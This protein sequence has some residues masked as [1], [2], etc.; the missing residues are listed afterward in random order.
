[1]HL[2]D[3]AVDRVCHITF[4]CPPG[5]TFRL[6]EFVLVLDN[7]TFDAFALT[8]DADTTM[9]MHFIAGLIESAVQRNGTARDVITLVYNFEWKY[10]FNFR[11][12]LR[13]LFVPQGDGE[14]EVGDGDDDDG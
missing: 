2:S 5:Y 14:E 1:M 7:G 4:I 13:A 6:I 11:P 10:T 12:T 9:S 8:S 3:Q